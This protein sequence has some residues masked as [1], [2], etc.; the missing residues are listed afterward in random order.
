MEKTI[1]NG[2]LTCFL[3][4]LTTEY[5]GEM[6][7]DDFGKFINN[8]EDGLGKMI[9]FLREKTG[10]KPLFV[11]MHTFVIG[12]DDRSFDRRFAKKYVCDGKYEICNRV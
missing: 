9:L 1:S 7:S 6:A 10:L 12:K 11:P 3:R 5:S 2:Y 4:E 8:F